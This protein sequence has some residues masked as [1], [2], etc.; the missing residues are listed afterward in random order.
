MFKKRYL[1]VLKKIKII[2]WLKFY[3]WI[4]GLAWTYLCLNDHFLLFGK[5]V[6]QVKILSWI[7][8]RRRKTTAGSKLAP[9]GKYTWASKNKLPSFLDY[10]LVSVQKSVLSTPKFSYK[11]HSYVKLCYCVFNYNIYFKTVIYSVT[12]LPYILYSV[13]IL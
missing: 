12:I 7:I 13:Y 10:L 4:K 11:W 5:H 1:H 3:V 9:T 8:G 6:S 2:D